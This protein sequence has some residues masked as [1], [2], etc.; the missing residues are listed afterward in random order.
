MLSIQDRHVAEIT[1]NPETETY[2]G[3]VSLTYSFHDD[4]DLQCRANLW[5]EAQKPR[6]ARYAFV[7]AALCEAASDALLQRFAELEEG[8]TNIFA[9]PAPVFAVRRAA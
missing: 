1:F 6:R 9:I 3:L 5:A 8:P 7:E 4:P 2:R